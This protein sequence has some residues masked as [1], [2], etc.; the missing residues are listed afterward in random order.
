M[1]QSKN[2]E[3]NS[4]FLGDERFFEMTCVIP[5]HTGLPCIIWISTKMGNQ[6]AHIKV[7]GDYSTKMNSNQLFRV[8]IANR[9]QVIGETRELSDSDIE[10]VKEFVKLNKRILLDFWNEVEIDVVK[11]ILQLKQVPF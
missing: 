11:V 9:P 3:E 1:Q 7:Q 6:E 2:T 10:Y 5:K 4:Q 8:T